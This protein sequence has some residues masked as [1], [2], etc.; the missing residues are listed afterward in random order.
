MI[1]T[2]PSTFQFQISNVNSELFCSPQQ[3]FLLLNMELLGYMSSKSDQGTHPMSKTSMMTDR[4]Q[5]TEDPPTTPPHAPPPPP[6]FGQVLIAPP[7][8]YHDSIQPAKGLPQVMLAH[9][10]KEGTSLT[11]TFLVCALRRRLRSSVNKTT[12]LC[13]LIGVSKQK[14]KQKD[15]ESNCY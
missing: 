7:T 1:R 5:A 13:N 11:G 15:P 2:P 8:F 4:W 9:L 6:Q 14:R 3:N 12:S 10:R